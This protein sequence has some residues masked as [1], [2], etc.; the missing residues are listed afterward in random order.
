MSDKVKILST[1]QC[2][3]TSIWCK[4]K[5]SVQASTN[6]LTVKRQTVTN[7]NLRFL[8]FEKSEDLYYIGQTQS[9][10]NTIEF[11]DATLYHK[12]TFTL[13]FCWILAAALIKIAAVAFYW[14]LFGQ[15]L[16]KRR[17]MAVLAALTTVWGL[18]TVRAKPKLSSFCV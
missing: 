2:F 6:M 5:S 17:I 12:A 10:T 4:Q 14:R 7:S 1:A 9:I 15:T 13:E 16:R 18:S 8:R 11:D 3:V